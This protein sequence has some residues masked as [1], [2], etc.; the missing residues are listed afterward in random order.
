MNELLISMLYFFLFIKLSM[1]HYTLS[2]TWFDHQENILSC[3]TLHSSEL[4]Q[5]QLC[6]NRSKSIDSI[7]VMHDS[8][9]FE[10]CCM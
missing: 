2:Y 3:D 6:Y 7:K 4:T 1:P 8:R 10:V 9:Y 5:F